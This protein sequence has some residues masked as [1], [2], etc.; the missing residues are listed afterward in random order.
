MLASDLQRASPHDILKAWQDGIIGY[1]EAMKLT[2]CESL[3]ELYQACRSSGVAIR[4]DL[5]E[6]ESRGVDAAV[7]DLLGP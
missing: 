4:S 2:D 6:Q 3:F 5:T 7:A 1:R